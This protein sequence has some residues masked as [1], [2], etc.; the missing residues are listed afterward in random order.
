MYYAL[1]YT[2]K[3]KDAISYSTVIITALIFVAA[4][5]LLSKP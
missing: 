4:S 3:L 1:M 5:T 2:L